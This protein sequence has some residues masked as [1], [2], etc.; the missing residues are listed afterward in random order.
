[1]KTTDEYAAA[2]DDLERMRAD[3]KIDQSRYEVH[4][5]ALLGEVAQQGGS[6][7]LRTIRTLVAIPVV[8]FLIVLVLRILGSIQNTLGM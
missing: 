1:M 5:A 6:Q 7:T 3:G 4:R 2:L 8:L